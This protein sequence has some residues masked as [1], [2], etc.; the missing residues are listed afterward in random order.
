MMN[1]GHR[2]LIVILTA[3]LVRCDGHEECQQKFEFKA[4]MCRPDKP[5]G[6]LYGPPKNISHCED[7][8]ISTIIN[9]PYTTYFFR[10]YMDILIINQCCGCLN[11]T[12]IYRTTYN[13]TTEFLQ[14]KNSGTG[15]V[16]RIIY[17]VLGDPSQKKYYGMYFVPMYYL[18]EGLL[19]T[20]KKT[21]GEIVT[22]LLFRIAGLWPLLVIFL[23]MAAISGFILWAVETR[24]NREAFR[25]P[26]HQGFLDGFWW[27]FVSMTT[28]G[29]G[30]KVPIT[31]VGRLFSS[32]WIIGGIT[33]CSILTASMTD[34][35]NHVTLPKQA[36]LSGK[37]GILEGRLF[38]TQMVTRSGGTFHEMPTLKDLLDTLDSNE[39]SGILLDYITK[40]Y[41][42]P[43]AITKTNRDK[44]LYRSTSFQST[45]HKS[46]TYGALFREE[47][48]ANFFRNVIYQTA[49]GVEICFSRAFRD[50]MDYVPP[51]LF[52]PDSKIFQHS[53]FVFFAILVCIGM[54]GILYEC[55][56]KK[57]KEAVIPAQGSKE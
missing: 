21:S 30:D 12:Q 35:I 10:A 52:S 5:Q 45:A 26:F 14:R 36:T 44:N 33:L 8:S 17:P 20:L 50:K 54:F 53:C 47:R 4:S 11:F 34:V 1:L 51:A 41:L 24:R 31:W 22:D 37:V 43:K 39:I 16:E 49:D 32:F 48:D 19:I 28:V 25:R 42:L 57:K 40:N 7:L 15:P 9:E 27:G 2:T 29:Y 46:Y 56:R 6:C 23:L 55:R 3:H 13:D 38:E 18:E